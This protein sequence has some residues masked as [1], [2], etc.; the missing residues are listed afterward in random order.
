M[1]NAAAFCVY[2]LFALFW[3]ILSVGRC[4]MIKKPGIN[5]GVTVEINEYWCHCQWVIKNY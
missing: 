4:N 5:D 3:I 1:C 2:C